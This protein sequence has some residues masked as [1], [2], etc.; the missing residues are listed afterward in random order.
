M[1]SIATVSAQVTG[2]EEQ[3]TISK[4]IAT[5][6]KKRGRTIRQNSAGATKKRTVNKN[7]LQGRNRDNL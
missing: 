6:A 4:N 3:N 7:T 5:E 2:Q 1:V